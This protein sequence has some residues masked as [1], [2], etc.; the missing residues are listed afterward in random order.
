MY[1]GYQNT[2][3][4]EGESLPCVTLWSSITVNTKGIN[5]LKTSTSVPRAD[6][7]LT[8]LMAELTIK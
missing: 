1:E 8:F 5:T 2:T 3:T 4:K 6:K 7:P